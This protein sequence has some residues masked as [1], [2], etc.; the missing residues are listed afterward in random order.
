MRRRR[1]S[2]DSGS[3]VELCFGL[4]GGVN[5]YGYANGSP[6]RYADPLGLCACAGGTWDQ[7]FGD[8]GAQGA[9]GGF[10]SVTNVSVSCRSNRSIRCTYRQVCIG[11][12]PIAG[13]GLGWS[14]GGVITGA[15]DSRDLSGWGGLQGTIAVGPFSGQ[16]GRK[17]GGTGVGVSIG[18]A[19][20]GAL[21]RCHADLLRCECTACQ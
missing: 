20:G 17:E 13:G 15:P 16:A 8:F 4:D 21:I 5:L 19:M 10:F 11:G 2:G 9:F 12:G 7:S 6:L 18:Y 3:G 1:R 14:L